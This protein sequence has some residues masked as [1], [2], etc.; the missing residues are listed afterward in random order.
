[1]KS[2]RVLFICAS[3]PPIGGGAAV[4]NIGIARGLAERGWDVTVLTGR[5]RS[6]W[7]DETPL[8]AIPRG[9][10]IVRAM[11]PDPAAAARYFR[12][13][14]ARSGGAATARGDSALRRF[15]L[16]WI[17][18][19]DA[20]VPWVPFAT[21]AAIALARRCSFDAVLSAGPPH[22]AHLVGLAVAPRVGRWIVDAQDPWAD[23][24]FPLSAS[25]ARR[26]IDRWLE[27]R[28]FRRAHAVISATRT[29]TKRFSA[30]YGGVGRFVT[31]ASGFDEREFAGLRPYHDGRRRMVHLGSFYGAR[32]PG[33][34]L[35]ALGDLA[36][37][38]PQMLAGWDI[39]LAGYADPGS[40]QMIDASMAHPV[41]RQ[42]VRYIPQLARRTALE[43]ALGADVLLLVTDPF[44][45]GREL[46]PL[47]TFEYLRAGRPV[48]A[49]V[50]RGETA[51]L[52]ERTGGALVAD[53]DDRQAISSA[54]ERALTDPADLDRPD[55][56]IVADLSFDRGL[57]R[58]SA[59]LAGGM[60]EDV[61]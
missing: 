30:A 32:T 13:R 23:H 51:A 26:G 29:Q 53:P 39:V 31:I 40:A 34:F 55:E 15:V 60:V 11:S 27:G 20:E 24:P 45:G 14:R 49:L 37:E 33:P 28:V 36:D 41:L 16:T 6:P 50:P 46:I 3:F 59:L 4:R 7:D 22:S 54:V 17:L 12:R 25:R 1:M 58:I 43:L 44:G 48:L 5:K 38:R 52:L 35:D 10:K 56:R 57:D 42:V 2:R 18:I 61:G 8:Q 47:K 9:M 19:P 21:A